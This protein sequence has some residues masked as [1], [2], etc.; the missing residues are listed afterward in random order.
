MSRE[1][2]DKIYRGY[3]LRDQTRL[4]LLR[5]QANLKELEARRDLDEQRRDA[6][7]RELL[8]YTGLHAENPIFHRLH[9]LLTDEV[10]SAGCINSL[11][12]LEQSYINIKKFVESADDAALQQYFI[13]H[14][15]LYQKIT[16]ERDLADNHAL[17]YTEN[18][19]P[20]LSVRGLYDRRD[21]TQ[22]SKFNG[23]GSLALVFSVPLFT[24]GT[25]IS[26]SKTRTMA[27]Q[28]ADV[29]QYADLRKTVHAIE[30]NRKL[31]VSLDKVYTIQQINLR[32]QYEIVV[33]SLK[34]YAIKQTSMQ[35]L[36][37]SKN[38]LIDA[39][40]ALMETTNQLGYLYR[41]FAWQLG[42]PYPVPAIDLPPAEP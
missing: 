24:G 9:N 13:E 6:A 12:N 39:K 34:S 40:N 1:H 38:R 10:S 7:F 17:T 42:T 2:V 16:L 30:N 18:E 26:N 15:L 28:I 5:S 41:E 35:D 27:Q 29:T 33:L 32:Q 14:S 11:S 25:I 8:D 22:F 21:D 20:A 3:E 31:I 19:W 36:L 4:Q 23:E 37:T